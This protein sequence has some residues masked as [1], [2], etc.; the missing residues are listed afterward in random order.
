MDINY[1]KMHLVIDRY[2]QGKLAGDEEAEFEERLVW[3]KDLQEQVE[4]AETLRGWLSDSV[5]ENKYTM[6][7]QRGLLGWFGS[8]LLAPAY[9]AAASFMVGGLIAYTAFNNPATDPVF[10]LD[11]SAPSTI[12]PLFAT[13][14]S[15]TNTQSIPVTAGAMTMLLI[16]VPDVDQS[17]RIEVRSSSSSE[18]VWTQEPLT[19]GY[20]DTVAVGIPGNALPPGTYTLTIESAG[21]GT[22][23]RQQ[24]SF[25]SIGPE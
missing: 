19:V 14:G 21:S 11:E 24:I 13:R 15:G 22:D 16:D 2:V 12:M 8:L 10:R 4:L 23:F 9:A 1:I 6:S 25:K 3:D 5:D 20:L 18:P 17:Y 7:G